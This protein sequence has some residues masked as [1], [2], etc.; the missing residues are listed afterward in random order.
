[1]IISPALLYLSMLVIGVALLCLAALTSFLNVRRTVQDRRSMRR[2]AVFRPKVLAALEDE[3]AAPI[4]LTPGERAAFITLARNLLPT[5]R[6]SERV[7]LTDLL[8]ECHV[9]DVALRDLHARTAVRRARAADLLGLAGVTRAA[10]AL[11]TLLED[12]DEDVRRTAARALGYVDDATSVPA[13][14]QT[15]EKRT[16]P[17]NTTTMAL[18]RMGPEALAP[19]LDGLREG[20]VPVRAVCAELLGLRGS[21]AALQALTTALGPS[22]ALEVRIRAARALG[23]IGAP[24][25]VDP[26]AHAMRSDEPTPLRAVAARALGQ[27]G[28]PR[29]VTLLRDALDAPEHMVS[30]NAARA[31]ASAGEE[32]AKALVRASNDRAA[33]RGEY[34]REGLSVITL[35]DAAMGAS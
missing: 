6:G 16:V 23:R 5:L 31:L 2:L 34:A 27:V 32:G 7:R 30:M 21:V 29:T 20:T 24:S 14:L 17:L 18:L 22:E 12:R 25:S 26:L 3:S 15:I 8:E 33:R 4:D 13:L 1:V 19:L 35:R 9:I 28:G 11:V 10:P